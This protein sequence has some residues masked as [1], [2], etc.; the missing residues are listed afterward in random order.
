MNATRICTANLSTSRPSHLLRR[1]A[2]VRLK[3]G[4]Y[5]RRRRR[6]RRETRGQRTGGTVQFLESSSVDVDRVA[7]DGGRA[8]SLSH[9]DRQPH[10]EQ[11]AVLRPRLHLHLRRRVRQLCGPT[12]SA[13]SLSTR[14]ARTRCI[15]AAHGYRL[16][17]WSVC[18]S[19]CR[20][21]YNRHLCKNG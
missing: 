2:A 15:D 9:L 18:L 19:A 20:V 14:I 11:S 21:G 12:A 10:H 5:S 17:A 6:R 16:A 3:H 7:G 13:S 4:M 8:R 1:C